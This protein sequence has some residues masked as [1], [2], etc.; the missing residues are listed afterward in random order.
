MVDGRTDVHD[1][2]ARSLDEPGICPAVADALRAMFGPSSASALMSR[3]DSICCTMVG[4]E[5]GFAVGLLVLVSGPSSALISTR[6]CASAAAS[7]FGLVLGLADGICLRLALA[8][9][10][11]V[12]W[13]AA[14]SRASA[15]VL[16]IGMAVSARRRLA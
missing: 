9:S 4:W 10:A 7:A 6:T 14:G 8:S 2:R 1:G 3:H 5:L 16:L 12:W 13:G 15:L 11:P